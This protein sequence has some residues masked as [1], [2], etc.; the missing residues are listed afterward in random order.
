MVVTESNKIC[1]TNLEFD[2]TGASFKKLLSIN[3]NFTAN[4][5]ACTV[6]DRLALALIDSGADINVVDKTFFEKLS[7]TNNFSEI[8]ISIE[9]R[10]RLISANR[11]ELSYAKIVQIPIQLGTKNWM[12]EFFV[13]E[14]VP[15]EVII[16]HET[17]RRIG[18]DI[19]T[20]TSE[21]QYRNDFGEVERIPFA[22]NRPHI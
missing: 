18:A 8:D 2:T 12:D 3:S 20:S 21:L 16:G 10:P 4:K 11:V 15:T 5:V 7:T 9:K 19:L 6:G 14:G 13:V 1:S 22:T 17:L